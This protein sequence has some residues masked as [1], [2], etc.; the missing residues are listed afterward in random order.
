MKRYNSSYLQKKQ[1]L[2]KKIEQT[3]QGCRVKNEIH[4]FL[5]D[6]YWPR[7]EK[8]WFVDTLK[9]SA[10][11]IT[12]NIIQ[13]SERCVSPSPKTSNPS[14]KTTTSLSR[15]QPSLTSSW[16]S[17]S[18]LPSDS[19]SLSMP[20]GNYFLTQHRYRTSWRIFRSVLHGRRRYNSSPFLCLRH[21]LWSCL[22]L[23]FP[24]AWTT[25]KRCCRKGH[26]Q[27]KSHAG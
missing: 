8:W 11:N 18:S 12:I 24:K 3:Y 1:A 17:S 20:W 10:F 7:E 9:Y 16:V 6:K 4:A 2:K 27:G 13:L 26:C 22:V 21:R 14:S 15:D 25:Q 23:W 19:S 5:D